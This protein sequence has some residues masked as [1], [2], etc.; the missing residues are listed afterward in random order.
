MKHNSDVCRFENTVCHF[1]WKL[2]HFLREQ[3]KFCKSGLNFQLQY[4]FLTNN[5]LML[6]Q[7][8]LVSMTGR[9]E[10]LEVQE[11]IS[12]PKCISFTVSR[13]H[14]DRLFTDPDWYIFLLWG[15][16]W[17]V[18]RLETNLEVQ[19][20][21]NPLDLTMVKLTIYTEMWQW[22]KFSKSYFNMRINHESVG[23][24]HFI[25]HTHWQQ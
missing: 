24:F 17:G 16:F 9:N 5:I 3:T 22:N 2:R 12:Q 20:T 1:V 18:S 21:I 14:C 19:A 6:E 23:L 10:K 11:K 15:V 13:L 8:Y 4:C 25:L 7:S